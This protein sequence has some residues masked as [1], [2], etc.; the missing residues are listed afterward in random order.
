MKKRQNALYE[1]L[2][3]AGEWVNQEIVAYELF[4]YYGYLGDGNFNNSRARRI[5]TADIQAINE[6]LNVEKIIIQGNKGIKI[7]S[8]EEFNRYISSQ[9]ASVFRKLKRIRI[10]EQK[11]KK[12]NC[13]MFDNEKTTLI[14]AFLEKI[15]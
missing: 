3:D 12:H 6:D 15:D 1:F 2:M 8:Q 14:D 4:E 11:A 13:Y 7:A 10:K 9:Y 5:M